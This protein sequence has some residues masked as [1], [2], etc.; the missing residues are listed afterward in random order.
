MR[1]VSTGPRRT[2]TAWQIAAEHGCD[3][4]LIEANLRKTPLERIRVHDRVLSAAL[5]L[6]DAV[7]KKYAI[8]ARRE[9]Q[10]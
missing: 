4:F 5:A 1:K 6:R 8:K 9:L 7:N 2:P 3:M 10:P